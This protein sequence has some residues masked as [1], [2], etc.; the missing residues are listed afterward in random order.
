[1]RTVTLLQAFLVT[2]ACSSGEE[3]AQPPA[4]PDPAVRLC[5]PTLDVDRS[6]GFLLANRRQTTSVLFTGGQRCADR[7]VP[8]E[9]VTVEL[10]DA[11]DLTVD[12]V[13]SKQADARKA[14]M[15]VTLEMGPLAP[16][17]IVRGTFR[18]EP[19]L[20]VIPFF[21]TVGEVETPQFEDTLLSCAEVI[22]RE[23]GSTCVYRDREVFLKTA[24]GLRRLGG[25]SHVVATTQHV[26]LFDDDRVVG[27]PI[28]GQGSPVAV[29]LRPL[30]GL[31]GFQAAATFGSTLL[32]TNTG[33][34]SVYRP[35]TGTQLGR[36]LDGVQ[37]PE[38]V[39]LFSET[40]AR[41]AVGGRW[42]D[43]DISGLPKD[44]KEQLP[45][46]DDRILTRRSGEGFWS[47]REGMIEL[48]RDDG[49]V[50]RAAAPRGVLES[51]QKR[52]LAQDQFR[53]E[54]ESPMVS[55]GTLADGRPVAWVPIDDGDG[56]LRSRFVAA[57]PGTSFFVANS[58]TVFLNSTTGSIATTPRR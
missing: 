27:F 39:A 34:I 13:V 36:F 56:G 21:W 51:E 37:A 55:M 12:A 33:S 57:P 40:R 19:G 41:L 31:G 42:V 47:L 46:S 4:A 52:L 44:F 17:T 2:M 25:S 30:R 6:F 48:T 3:I 43:V 53:F 50:S 14:T 38:A 23:W 24:Q 18:A 9:D 16:G 32:V 10:V 7:M 11:N 54:D 1:M 35:E 45:R 8:I 20:G 29:S 49:G 5:T 26:W 58:E 15:G 28:S 22:R